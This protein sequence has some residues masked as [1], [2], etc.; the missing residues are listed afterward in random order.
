[1][2]IY[3]YTYYIYIYI[4]C[5]AGQRRGQRSQQKISRGPR[6]EAPTLKGLLMAEHPLS[7]RQVAAQLTFNY[8]VWDI[9][10]RCLLSAET[11]PSPDTVA[12]A[13]EENAIRE[14]NEHAPK[15]KRIDRLQRRI[16]GFWKKNKRQKKDKNQHQRNKQHDKSE[17]K[18]KDDAMAPT[19]AESTGESESLK[20]RLFEADEP[21]D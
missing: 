4:L 1:M 2:Y 8:A 14:W 3:I 6:T 15:E 17:N 18:N 10:K 19:T 12:T 16:T 5:S 13:I 20:R 11:T 21:P 7:K 9:R